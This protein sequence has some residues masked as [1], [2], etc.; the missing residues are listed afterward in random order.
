MKNAK[1]RK[2]LKKLR[3]IG[4][5]ARGLEVWGWLG[6]KKFYRHLPLENQ[7]QLAQ[8]SVNLRGDEDVIVYW[9]SRGNLCLYTLKK[10]EIWFGDTDASCADFKNQSL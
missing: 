7:I 10:V 4:C 8:L 1:L 3:L 9:A 5:V 2:A 6:E